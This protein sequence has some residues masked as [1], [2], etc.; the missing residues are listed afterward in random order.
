L[1]SSRS[2]VLAGDERETLCAF[3]WQKAA[4][5]AVATS[6]WRVAF[7]EALSFYGSSQG[8]DKNIVGFWLAKSRFDR[9]GPSSWRAGFFWKLS[10]YGSS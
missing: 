6:F 9:R 1:G 4:L 3:G 5:I 7:L 2:T 10:F 8:R